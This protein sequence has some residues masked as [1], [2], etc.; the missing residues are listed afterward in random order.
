MKAKPDARTFSILTTSFG[1]NDNLQKAE[2]YVTEATSL[3]TFCDICY[4]FIIVS[5]LII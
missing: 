3:V 4:I 1:N 2:Y 5:Y